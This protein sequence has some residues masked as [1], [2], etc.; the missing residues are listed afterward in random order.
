MHKYELYS[1]VQ[2]FLRHCCVWGPLWVPVWEG[3]I[4]PKGNARDAQQVLLLRKSHSC[5]FIL[6]FVTIMHICN[7]Q[8]RK[9]IKGWHIVPIGNTQLLVCLLSLM[10]LWYEFHHSEV[11]ENAASYRFVWDIDIVTDRSNISNSYFA[12]IL[13]RISKQ[14]QTIMCA[15]WKKQGIKLFYTKVSV[16]CRYGLVEL[17]QFCSW[18]IVSMCW[19]F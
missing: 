6:N 8:E 16:I 2:W 10:K 5:K 12:F 4:N 13:P 18:N 14:K 3:G 7:L 15:S 9:F 17:V 11:N 1:K 19:Q